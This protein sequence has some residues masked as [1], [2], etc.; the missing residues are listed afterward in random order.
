MSPRRGNP[1]LEEACTGVLGGRVVWDL[2][3]KIRH[4][5]QGELP[6]RGWGSCLSREDDAAH[7]G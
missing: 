4:Q 6:V 1:T 2:E 5:R 3:P 7:S